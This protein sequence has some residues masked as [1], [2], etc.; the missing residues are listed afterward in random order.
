MRTL[1]SILRITLRLAA[2]IAWPPLRLALKL[3]LRAARLFLRFL[4]WMDADSS[5]FAALT[6]AIGFHLYQK[7]RGF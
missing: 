4:N 5:V 1:F 7:K 3:K 6:L 2:A